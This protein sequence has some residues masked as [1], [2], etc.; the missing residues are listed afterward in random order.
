MPASVKRISIT[1]SEA[2]YDEWVRKADARGNSIAGLLRDAVAYL[3]QDPNV[4]PRTEKA[5]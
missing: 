1:V 2:D 4:H 5:A 3:S